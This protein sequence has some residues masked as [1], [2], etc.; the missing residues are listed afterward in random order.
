VAVQQCGDAVGVGQDA[1]DVG[2]GREAAHAHWPVDANHVAQAH[3]H[4]ID[5]LD[6]SPD[7]ETPDRRPSRGARFEPGVWWRSAITRRSI[8]LR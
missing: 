5:V 1:G 8:G 6:G 7:Q 3:S 2:G 4:T